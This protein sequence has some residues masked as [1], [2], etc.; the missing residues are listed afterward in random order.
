MK[1]IKLL[2]KRDPFDRVV[3]DLV[4]KG[5]LKIGVTFVKPGVDP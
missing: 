2:N 3:I 1:P 5:E 4:K